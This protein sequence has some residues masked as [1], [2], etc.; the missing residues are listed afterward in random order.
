MLN[1]FNSCNRGFLS[2]FESVQL[3][4]VHPSK[5]AFVMRR[6]RA[7][8]HSVRQRIRSCFALAIAVWALRISRIA[9]FQGIPQSF[10]KW[11]CLSFL[12]AYC[13]PYCISINARFYNTIMFIRNSL[14]STSILYAFMP[15]YSNREL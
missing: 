4:R 10:I 1:G 8:C 7:P 5:P 15:I 9:R 12:T 3:I 6:N 13:Y 2:D 11:C 14:K